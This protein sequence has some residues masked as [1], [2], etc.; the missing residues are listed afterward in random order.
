M[1]LSRETDIKDE[2]VQWGYWSAA[3]GLSL[4]MATKGGMMPQITDERA[5]AIDR[6]VAILSYR[7]SVA[8]LVLKATYIQRFTTRE[9]AKRH[10]M[11]KDKVNALLNMAIGC[12][13]IGLDVQS[14]NDDNY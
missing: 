11:Q 2:L 10:N 14:A 4:T 6:V 7:D 9:I 13:A 8:G 3:S 1:L 12:V 5:L